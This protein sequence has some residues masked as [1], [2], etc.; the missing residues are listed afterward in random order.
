[1]AQFVDAVVCGVKIH[2]MLVMKSKFNGY[3]VH[4]RQKFA[5]G[6]QIAYKPLSE[7]SPDQVKAIFGD[8]RAY[9]VSVQW[10][11]KNPPETKGSFVPSAFQNTILDTV[12]NTDK[13]VLISALAGSGKTSTLVWLLHEL[14][15]RNLL[16][17]QSVIYL[18]FNK[19]IQEEL[20]ERLRGTDVESLTTHAFGLRILR[21]KFAKID[22]VNFRSGEI[23][24]KLLCDENGWDYDGGFK[25]ARKLEAYA[26]RPAVLELVSYIKNWAILPTFNNGWEFSA[27]QRQVIQNL[28]DIYEIEFDAKFSPETVVNYACYVIARSIPEPGDTLNQCDFDDMLYLPLALSLPV[29][30]YD[31]VLTDESQDFN[32]AQIKLIEKMI[33]A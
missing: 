15:N 30:H 8:N 24:L 17:G 23:F 13:H 4:A 18:A 33:A 12:I 16:K 21:K 27:E 7:L 29:P 5:T 20:A 3:D 31:L 14:K 28:I 19:S 6:T 22:P 25:N 9:A 10:P 32:M 2:R 11:L 26:L 1:M